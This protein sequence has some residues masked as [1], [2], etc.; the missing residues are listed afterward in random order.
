M[1]AGAGGAVVLRHHVT[2]QDLRSTPATAGL[3]P[4]IGRKG[5]SPIPGVR[6]MTQSYLTVVEEGAR[7]RFDNDRA[8]EPSHLGLTPNG[9]AG[10][11][12]SWTNC[13]VWQRFPHTP[14]KDRMSSGKTLELTEVGKGNYDKN[15]RKS[16]DGGGRT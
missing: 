15:S 1:T 10:E 4:G 12:L 6:I 9:G 13:L 3:P 16:I 2:S 14:S 11:A 5:E 8:I 7:V